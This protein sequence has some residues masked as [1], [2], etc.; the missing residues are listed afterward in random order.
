VYTFTVQNYNPFT[1]TIEIGIISFDVPAGWIV[2]TEPSQTLKLG[3]NSE[4]V[5]TVTVEIPCS[6]ALQETYALQEEIGG[7]PTIDVEAY[8]NGELVGGIELQLPEAAQDDFTIY[9]PVVLRD[10]Q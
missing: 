4:G 1:A 9:L 10:W 2:T 8:K 3:P 7:T 6:L 5:V